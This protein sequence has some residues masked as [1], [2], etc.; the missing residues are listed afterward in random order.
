MAGRVSLGLRGIE[1]ERGWVMIESLRWWIALRTNANL[2]DWME[3]NYSRR[4]LEE[5]GKQICNGPI[6]ESHDP[7]GDE[8]IDQFLMRIGSWDRC[9]KRIYKRYAG[10]VWSIC[11]GACDPKDDKTIF[12]GLAR[13]PYS[14]Q[15]QNAPGFEEFMV[16]NA[17][18][19]AASQILIGRGA[20]QKESFSGSTDFGSDS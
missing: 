12:E 18:R 2:W 19:V 5:I 8:S 3:S 14:D 17:M 20:R 11:L 15:V 6:Q 10:D 7:M 4:D 1:P 13:L 9:V 16:R